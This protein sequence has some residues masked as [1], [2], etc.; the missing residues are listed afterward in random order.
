MNP[1][2]AAV[3]AWCQEA[4]IPALVLALIAAFGSVGIDNTGAAPM[5]ERREPSV[6]AVAKFADKLPPILLASADAV[7]PSTSVTEFADKLPPIS[8]ASAE[9]VAPGRSVTETA[10]AEAINY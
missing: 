9:A 1:R 7:A 3:A 2:L 4:A 10:A 6:A 5:V 8:L